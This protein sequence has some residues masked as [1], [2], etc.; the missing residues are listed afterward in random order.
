MPS[1]FTLLPR[2]QRVA[3]DTCHL[4]GGLALPSVLVLGI[5]GC[6]VVNAQNS[7]ST[8]TFT[9]TSHS[10]VISSF[11]APCAGA[12]SSGSSAGGTSATTQSSPPPGTRSGA[13]ALVLAPGHTSGSLRVG[14]LVQVQL[15]ATEHWDLMSAPAS[16]PTSASLVPLDP[17]PPVLQLLTPGGWYN[18]PA[19]L[20]IWSFRAQA[21]KEQTLVFVATALCAPGQTCVRSSHPEAFTVQVIP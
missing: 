5:T 4:L 9:S 3:W 11:S 15:P 2:L 17:S 16:S 19:K 20:C 14:Q 13:A 18:A 7:T 8:S 1:R 12:Q 6:G 10:G 21:A